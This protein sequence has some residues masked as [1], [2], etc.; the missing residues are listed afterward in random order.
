M[1]ALYYLAV[2]LAERRSETFVSV[3]DKP[4]GSLQ[5]SF[6]ERPVQASRPGDV[7][8]R[9]SWI[10]FIKKP[11]APLGVCQRQLIVIVRSRTRSG[12]LP[13]DNFQSHRL[14]KSRNRRIGEQL[15]QRQCHSQG[16][17]YSRNKLGGEQGMTTQAKEIVVGSNLLY[18]EQV[19]KNSCNSRL[20]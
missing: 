8:G 5:G 19:T 14:G 17:A 12:L 9:R 6:V 16:I 18:L 10:Q 1:Y 4:H 11:E 15:S 2:R 13:G 3:R 7:V 20:Q